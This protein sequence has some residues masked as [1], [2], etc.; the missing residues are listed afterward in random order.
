MAIE[1]EGVVVAL[2]VKECVRRGN[3]I[4]GNAAMAVESGCEGKERR[5]SSLVDPL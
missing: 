4:I 5:K 2:N 3:Y 1:L